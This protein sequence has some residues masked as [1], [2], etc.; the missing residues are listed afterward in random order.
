MQAIVAAGESPSAGRW[1]AG[2]DTAL[3][4]LLGF[5]LGCD[6]RSAD[7][8]AFTYPGLGRPTPNALATQQA[9]WGAAQH[10]FPLG[11]VTFGPPRPLCTAR[12]HHD[13]HPATSADV[14][15]AAEAVAATPAVHGLS[16]HRGLV[17]SRTRALG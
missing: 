16:S 13:H 1:I 14:V 9:V 5:Q 11:P 7:Q 15:P 10:A 12:P 3:S 6:A 4:A 8:G 2:T 17:R